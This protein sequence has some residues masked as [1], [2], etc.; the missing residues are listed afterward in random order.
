MS[1]KVNLDI[2]PS[3]IPQRWL[4]CHGIGGVEKFEDEFSQDERLCQDW[5]IFH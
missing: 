2:G 4:H 1:R 3:P 5:Q